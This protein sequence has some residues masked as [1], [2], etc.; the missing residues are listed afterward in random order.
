MRPEDRDLGFVWDMRIA[1]ID[2]N[3]F[4]T[5]VSLA[6]FNQNLLLRYAIERQLLVIGETANH[7]SEK[8]KNTH[9]E[10]PWQILIG[11]RNILAHQY[12]EIIAEK[13]WQTAT[14]DIPDL[15]NSLHKILA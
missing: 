3:N 7:V 6:K 4:I 12:G 2:I 13:I 15:L 5:G 11:Q 10:I 1:A 14:K 8:F 9:T